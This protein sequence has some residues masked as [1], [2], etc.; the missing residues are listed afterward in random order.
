MQITLQILFV[1]IIVENYVQMLKTDFIRNI[2]AENSVEN[3]KSV[4]GLTCL[5][6]FFHKIKLNITNITA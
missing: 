4:K 6:N 3:V 1:E 5:N 2:F